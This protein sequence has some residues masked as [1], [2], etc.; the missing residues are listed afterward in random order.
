MGVS[1]KWLVSWKIPNKNGWFGGSPIFGPPHWMIY[2]RNIAEVREAMYGNAQLLELM[3][4][5]MYQQAV[6]SDPRNYFG[7][8]CVDFKDF[9]SIRSVIFRGVK[10]VDASIHIYI[11]IQ[12]I[13]IYIYI[14]YIYISYNEC[15]VYLGL[16][17]RLL[18][19]AFFRM[20]CGEQPS[21]PGHGLRSGP[22]G[23]E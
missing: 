3:V 17:G 14:L 11:Y 18:R 12:Y 21:L 16:F 10:S 15:W 23:G 22:G 1:P 20:T 4:K 13:Y 8:C 2:R 7:V 9:F 19:P 5:S 6:T